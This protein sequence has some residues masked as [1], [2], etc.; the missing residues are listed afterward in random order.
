MTLESPVFLYWGFF[1]FDFRTSK[2]RH[3]H[4][5]IYF[6]MPIYRYINARFVSILPN[7]F[8]LTS[9]YSSTSLPIHSETSL[10]LDGISLYSSIDL[11]Y[12][13]SKWNTLTQKK[14]PRRN[15]GIHFMIL[16][17]VYNNDSAIANN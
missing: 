12:D 8:L 14:S 9:N 11:P 10:G 3:I 4:I 1:T 17:T 5:S 16:L 15:E 2:Y 6:D 13:F 7:Q